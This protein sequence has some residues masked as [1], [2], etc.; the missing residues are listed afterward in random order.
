MHHDKV[1]QIII[2][3]ILPAGVF[4]LLFS[5]MSCPV[6]NGEKG[7]VTACFLVEPGISVDVGE[8]VFFDATCGNYQV[9]P[10]NNYTTYEWDFGDGYYMQYNKP[11]IYHM[12]AGITCTHFFTTPGTFTVTLTVTS[13]TGEQDVT[14]KDIIVTGN[15]RTGK[16]DLR[17]GNFHGHISQ[18]I[19]AKLGEDYTGPA[20]LEVKIEKENQ[21]YKELY[22]GTLNSGFEAKILLENAELPAGN[23]TL[24]ARLTSNNRLVDEIREKFSKPYNGIPHI[25]INKEN[26][27]CIDGV[28]VFPVTPFLLNKAHF[29][30]W[31]DNIVNCTFGEGF[32]NVHNINTWVDYCYNNYHHD[33]KAIG[34]VKWDGEGN[35]R[36]T[37]RNSDI[38][39]LRE[40]VQKTKANPGIYMWCWDDEVNMGGRDGYIPAPVVRSWTYVTHK[41]D[42]Q[43]LVMGTMYGYDFLP[44]YES[45]TVTA[46]AYN[47]IHNGDYFGGRR[48]FPFD[49]MDYDIFPLGHC[50][51]SSLGGAGDNTRLFEAYAEGIDNTIERSYNLYPIL[52]V[53]EVQ[54]LYPE[55][56]YPGPTPEQ[57]RMEI[58]MNIVHGMKGLS[59][60]HYFGVRPPENDAVL[61]EF[62]DQIKIW[63]ITI[64]GPEP[65]TTVTDDA[66]VLNTRVDTMVRETS[67][68]IWIYTVRITEI[69]GEPA[70]VLYDVSFHL[71]TGNS[72]EMTVYDLG[73]GTTRTL[74]ISGGNFQDDFE[75]Y[76]VHVYKIPK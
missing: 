22:S 32:Y 53:V 37:N 70:D 76:D 17:H 3:A 44:Y 18:Y 69:E 46:A 33:M 35:G 28:P 26:A 15:P 34:P 50:D 42:P 45:L 67:S 74:Q 72:E 21:P 10:E 54:D 31:G 61:A 29:A 55:D 25:G 58:W 64:L 43:H 68:D 38:N 11:T 19:Y 51:H 60:F 1:Y 52:S 49:V 65:D 63:G 47:Y 4:I 59:W 48:T 7:G 2:F 9:D 40:Y 8:E 62:V 57:L 73:A 20:Y 27:V 39:K 23:Y 66:N 30:E 56:S 13:V 14:T 12:D 5:L 16:L 24:A 41:Y 36:V 6:F 75:R 71:S